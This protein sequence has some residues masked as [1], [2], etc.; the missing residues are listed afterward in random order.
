MKKQLLR[1]YKVISYCL[2]GLIV[3]LTVFVLGLKMMGESPNILGYSIYYVMSGSMEPEIGVGDIIIGQTVDTKDLQ[4][5]DVITYKGDKG[6]VAGKIV[7]HKIIEINGN[8]ITTK[9]VANNIA[10][11]PVYPSQ[12][13][14]KYVC[15]VPFAGD[16]FTLLNT[17]FGFVFLVI[18]PLLILLVN[19]ILVIVRTVKDGKEEDSSE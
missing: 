2:F 6:T 16:I 1:I 13:I 18:T 12:V 7:T 19:E 17:K 3:L 9:G 10:D 5:G 14:S 15:R 4:V 8:E 11:P